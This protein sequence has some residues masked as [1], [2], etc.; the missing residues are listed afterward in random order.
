M[1]N[2]AKVGKLTGREY[3]LFDYVVVSKS[4]DT[5]EIKLK[6]GYSY[7]SCTAE[8]VVMMPE[9]TRLQF[10]GATQGS[11]RGFSSSNDLFISLSGASSLVM[12]D[13]EAG[14]L[15]LEVSGASSLG[16]DIIADGDAT[17]EISGASSVDISGSAGDLRADVSGASHL[18][19]DVFPLHNADVELSG[20]SNG[21]V[22]MDG[23]LNA[24]LSG[25]SNLYYIGE[26]TMGDIDTSGASNISRK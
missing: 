2:M 6:S 12:T 21:T 4:G 11:V 23:T 10:S 18:G 24:D 1:E 17:M 13:M 14:A 16:G 22:N 7:H 8:A 9:L 20:A 3:N 15:E 19:L 26:P 5:L 25:A